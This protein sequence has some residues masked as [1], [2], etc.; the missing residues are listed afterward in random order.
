MTCDEAEE[1]VEP[2]Q[3]RPGVILCPGCGKL[4]DDLEGHPQLLELEVG[5]EHVVDVL[6]RVVPVG[7][8]LTT[9]EFEIEV[10]ETLDRVLYIKVRRL[11]GD[12]V[13]FLEYANDDDNVDI[14]DS[15]QAIEVVL[16]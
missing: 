6:D 7:L 13:V 15:A 5:A 3:V 9:M 1:G 8:K 4:L 10:T 11:D 16:T 12:S 2:I 14:G